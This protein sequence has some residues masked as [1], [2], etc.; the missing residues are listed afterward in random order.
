MIVI[1]Q[2]E[3]CTEELD[4]SQQR[5]LWAYIWAFTLIDAVVIWGLVSFFFKP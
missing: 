2:T 5:E 3:D 4:R 1:H